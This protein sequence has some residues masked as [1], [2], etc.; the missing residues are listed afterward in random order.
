MA[1]AFIILLALTL[2]SFSNNVISFFLGSSPFDVKRSLCMCG[3]RELKAKELIPVIS[4]ILQKGRCISCRKAISYRYVIVEVCALVI[5]L[6]S[7]YIY[8]FN[9]YMAL[10]YAL[11]MALLLIGLVDLKKFIIPNV[12][13]IV[14]FV[15]AAIKLVIYGGSTWLNIISAVS[16][17]AIFILINFWGSRM[18]GK[19]LIGPGDIKLIIVM[20][21][22][23]DFPVSLLALWISAFIAIPGY[24]AIRRFNN[25]LKLKALVPFGFFMAIGYTFTELFSFYIFKLVFSLRF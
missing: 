3:D 1:Q 5:G 10:H 23:M 11:F 21:L 14:L 6:A 4:F 17:G 19:S 18:K 15:I 12:L 13:V 16:L 25:E 8:G 2:G 7:Y 9:F 22:F 20:T 24:Y